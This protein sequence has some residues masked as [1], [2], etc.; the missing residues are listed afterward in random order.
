[1]RLPYDLTTE[2]V[3]KA[4]EQLEKSKVRKASPPR[5]LT[6]IVS[7]VRFAVHKSDMLE[8][9]PET[10]NQRFNKWLGEHQ[11]R[12]GLQFTPEQKEWLEMIRNHI[13]TSLSVEIDDFEL[14][15]FQARGGA[16]KAYQLFDGDLD[17]I[18]ME[19]NEVLVAS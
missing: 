12:T 3:W 10:V 13:S 1:M 19:L 5:L 18:I 8:P 9:F 15:P 11:K 7:L 2:E 6:D 14:Q 16:V 17:G 4:Y